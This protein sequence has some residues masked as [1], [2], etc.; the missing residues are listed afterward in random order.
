[1]FVDCCCVRM[2]D[3]KIER[4][5]CLLYCYKGDQ[6][7]IDGFLSPGDHYG[8]SSSRSRTTSF[9]EETEEVAMQL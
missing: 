5:I 9:T 3:F 1:M 4:P 6:D 8:L 7:G 2:H